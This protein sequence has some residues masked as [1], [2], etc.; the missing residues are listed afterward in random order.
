VPTYRHRSSSS[1]ACMPSAKMP[2]DGGSSY[3]QEVPQ[4]PP[5]PSVAGGTLVPALSVSGAAVVPTPAAAL[6]M[7]VAEAAGDSTTGAS[8]A[9]VPNASWPEA[10]FPLSDIVRG[11]L[12]TKRRPKQT[13]STQGKNEVTLCVGQ[14]TYLVA[15]L[16]PFLQ[17]LDGAFLNILFDPASFTGPVLDV[18]NPCA[19][20]A[21][22]GVSAARLPSD[23][24]VVALA[25][26]RQPRLL[27]R[28][29]F[30]R[31]NFSWWCPMTSWT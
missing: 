29:R 18:D 30:R 24:D 8:G 2:P 7:L 31:R 15:D 11:T 3:G 28:R 21:G 5:S 25:T 23:V 14:L 16:R 27:Q 17:G 26:A 4:P 6:V 19:P 20:G 12:L 9:L 13:A 1:T 10:F 22:W